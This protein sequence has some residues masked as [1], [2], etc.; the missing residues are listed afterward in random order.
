MPKR[1]TTAPSLEKCVYYESKYD[2]DTLV[3]KTFS[4][5]KTMKL[6]AKEHIDI[7]MLGLVV[8]EVI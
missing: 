1:P 4:E 3:E 6:S 2:F 5:T 8:S 7:T